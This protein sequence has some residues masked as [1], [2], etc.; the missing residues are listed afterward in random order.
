MP[1]GVLGRSAVDACA[2]NASAGLE[3]AQLCCPLDGRPASGDLEFAVD[4]LGMG[5]DG[6]QGD[7]EFLGDLRPRQLGFEQS[8]HV[9]L[10]LAEG[11][12]EGLRAGA[13]E[14]R[15]RRLTIV[16]HVVVSLRA[17]RLW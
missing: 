14:E 4:A 1:C 8:E 13:V 15:W 2:G 10:T 6:A 7:H 16:S 17:P 3:Q 11:L 9:T 5:A 12:D